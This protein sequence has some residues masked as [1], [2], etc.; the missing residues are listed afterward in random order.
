MTRAVEFTDEELAL[1][2]EALEDAAVYR[3]AR[4]HVLQSA[5]RRRD[6]RRAIGSP[7][8]SDVGAD[9]RRKA[10]AYEALAL[11]LKRTS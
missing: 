9:H 10:L 6:R 1:L 5:V 8:D 2:L 7:A 3:D 4:S 11:K